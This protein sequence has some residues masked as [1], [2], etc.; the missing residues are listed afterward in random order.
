M[1]TKLRN[2]ANFVFMNL[3]DFDTTLQVDEKD[4]YP[5]DLRM[6]S[7]INTTSKAMTQQLNAYEY[8][9]AKL[10]FERFFRHDFCDNY[11][12]IIKDKIYK[13]EKYTHGQQQK[14]S[15]QFALYHTF[16]AI[17][18][19]IAPYLP[20][21]AEELYQTYYKN[22]IK[23]ASIHTLSFPNDDVFTITQDMKNI[24]ET[25][26]ELL[27]IIEKVRGYKTEKQL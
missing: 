22:D 13:P 2:A 19:L 1:I 6:L 18:K 3:A 25:V 26:D 7:Q 23:S 15:A 9:Q 11:L 14:V 10:E 16:A 27:T 12:E 24:N 5:I 8:G 21:I 17:I 4:L 20:F